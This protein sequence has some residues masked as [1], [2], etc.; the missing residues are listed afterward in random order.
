MKD[1][2][3]PIQYPTFYLTIPST[4]EQKEFRPWTVREDKALLIA[5]ESGEYSDFY[6]AI[7]NAIQNCCVEKI[8]VSRLAVFDYQ[9]LFIQIRARTVGDKIRLSFRAPEGVGCD[10]C[11]KPRT[12]EI[13]L[14]DIKVE[15]N[16]EHEK[17]VTL[18]DGR[19][20]FLRYP[21][22]T[23]NPK[24]D[25]TIESVYE[26]VYGCIDKIV[27]GSM[28][29]AVEDLEKDKVYD[30]IESMHRNDFA[31]I[32]HFIQTI[33]TIQHEI[34]ISCSA[35]GREEIYTVR[36]LEDFFALA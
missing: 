28:V 13:S 18:S 9:Y 17:K 23:R 30:F 4:G 10:V 5:L 35:C 8:D 22:V 1:P 16:P 7:R 2:L 6:L 34:D 32:E 3:R 27:D 33:P 29:S 36:G 19:I 25:E 21:E 20:L 12:F 11:S 24:D 14:L 31:K 15:H 26:S